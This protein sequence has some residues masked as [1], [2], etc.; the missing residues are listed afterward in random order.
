[1]KSIPGLQLLGVLSLFLRIAEFN[2]S[3]ALHAKLLTPV[4]WIRFKIA[5]QQFS[6]RQ[7]C[8]SV[9]ITRTMTTN[10]AIT[11]FVGLIV[12]LFSRAIWQNWLFYRGYI[13]ALTASQL[14]KIAN[15]HFDLHLNWSIYEPLK[16]QLNAGLEVC[17]FFKIW[18][19]ENFQWAKIIYQ[20]YMVIVNITQITWFPKLFMF[21]TG[22][23]Y[24]ACCW[25]IFTTSLPIYTVSQKTSPFYFCDIFVKLHPILLIF[26]RNMPQE[27]WN[28]HMYM[29]NSYLVLYV[30]TVPCKN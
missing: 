29:L 25:H 6:V 16:S 11:P 7:C 26:G 17:I 24:T 30:R 9:S 4:K 12:P 21:G 3:V 18:H 14:A 5:V 8:L 13:T 1:V 28:K 10:D 27:I 20:E 15:M 19:L 23:N 2:A 22:S